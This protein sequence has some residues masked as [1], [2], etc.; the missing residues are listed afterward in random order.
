MSTPDDNEF[1]LACAVEGCHNA[2]I[3]PE[4]HC[5]KHRTV[6]SPSPPDP[7]KAVALLLNKLVLASIAKGDNAGVPMEYRVTD[8]DLEKI[9]AQILAEVDALSQRLHAAEAERDAFKE[10]IH[11]ALY[12]LRAWIAPSSG[13]V[14]AAARQRLEAAVGQLDYEWNALR[15]FAEQDTRA[16]LE[17][18]NEMARFMTQKAADAQVLR[19]AAES[20]L[21]A[22]EQ[23]HTWRPIETA[24]RDGEA[25]CD[26]LR[27]FCVER[28]NVITELAR[29]AIA[30]KDAEIARL[31]AALQ[32]YTSQ[33]PNMPIPNL[34]NEVEAARVRWPQDWRDAHTGNANTEG[35]VRKLAAHLSANVDLRWG[36]NGKRGNPDDISDDILAYRGEGSAIDVRTGGPM[37]IIDIIGGAGGPNPQPV[38]NVGPGGPGDRGTWVASNIINPPPPPPPQPV[39]KPLEQFKAEFG[40]VNDFYASQPGLQRVG[41]IVSGVDASVWKVLQRYANGWPVDALALRNAVQAALLVTA[42]IQAMAQWGR[43]LM[44]GQTPAQVIQR[45]RQSDEWKAVH[46]GETP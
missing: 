21:R 2:V 13:E 15:Q 33:E 8:A 20:R 37:E 5:S 35:F 40:M 29:D 11:A 9:E 23:A 42:D 46:P 39:L 18:A 19:D 1:L 12:V 26:R 6:A 28:E 24:P 30:E 36:L 16:A 27:A 43:D 25:E 38:W 34:L 45:I 22:A 17:A 3:V 31:A 32:R 4:T 44:L 7:Q 41:G 10:A 14:L